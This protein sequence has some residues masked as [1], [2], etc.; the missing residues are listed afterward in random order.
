[1]NASKALD[2]DSTSAQVS[3]LESGVLATAALAVVLVADGHPADAFR[4]VVAR[5]VGHLAPIASELVADVVRLVVLEVDGA[6][7]HVVRDVVQVATVLEPRASRAYVIGRALTL[8][9]K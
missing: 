1:M 4:L 5:H 7:E 9:L 8:D 6:D 3:G 2:N